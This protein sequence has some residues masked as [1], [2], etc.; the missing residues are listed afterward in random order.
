MRYLRIQNIICR[1]VSNTSSRGLISYMRYLIIQDIIQYISYFNLY[2]ENIIFQVSSN[3]SSRG[4]MSRV[5]TRYLPMP[6]LLAT[7]KQVPILADFHSE[8]YRTEH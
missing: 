8:M 4:L 7:S 2:L 6:G 3:T 1:L 5:A